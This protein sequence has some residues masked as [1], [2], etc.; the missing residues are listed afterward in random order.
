MVSIDRKFFFDSVRHSLF[1]DILWQ[2]HVDGMNVI[3]DEFERRKY[4]DL[5]WCSYPLATAY[6]ETNFSM[7]PIHEMGGRAYF[8]RLYDI[9]GDYPQRA[10]DNE[11]RTPGDGI[12]YH[13]RGYVQLTW[14]RNYRIMAEILGLPELLENPDLALEPE[15]AVKIMY[16]GMTRGTFTGR[17]LDHYFNLLADEPVGARYIVNGQDRAREI[18]GYH[19]LFLTAVKG[20]F[21]NA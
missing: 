3:L 9:K 17:R 2:G 12:K 18:A 21:A 11:N 19:F 10:W 13:G 7:Q 8:T 1:H 20:E 5:R 4:D 16:E 14:R 15:I 6:V